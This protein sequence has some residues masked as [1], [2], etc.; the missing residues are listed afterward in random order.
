MIAFNEI[1][2]RLFFYSQLIPIIELKGT[3][4]NCI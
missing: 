2:S 1:R 4:S 3:N